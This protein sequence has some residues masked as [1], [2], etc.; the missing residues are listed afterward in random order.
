MLVGNP[1]LGAIS[2]SRHQATSEA[3]SVQVE[4]ASTNPENVH[5]MTSRYQ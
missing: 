2:L 1:D 4:K 5:T 3:L